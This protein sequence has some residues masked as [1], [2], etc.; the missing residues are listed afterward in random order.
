M[1]T[2]KHVTTTNSDNWLVVAIA[3][4]RPTDVMSNISQI[5]PLKNLNADVRSFNQDSAAPPCGQSPHLSNESTSEGKK[6]S[7]NIFR[8]SGQHK[9]VNL[10][11]FLFVFFI[12]GL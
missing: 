1:I 5:K 10:M 7:S 6:I 12:L 11:F 9:S 3:N 2:I 8:A 4:S